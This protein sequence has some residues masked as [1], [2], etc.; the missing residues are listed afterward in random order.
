MKPL[1]IIF[2]FVLL[3]STAFAQ[4][5]PLKGVVKDENEKPVPGVNIVVKGTAHGT[6]T[7]INGNYA[8]DITG[9]E[10]VVLYMLNGYKKFQQKFEAHNGREYLLDVTLVK[11][12]PANVAMKSYGEMDELKPQ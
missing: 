5:I 3:A 11:S 10:V 12:T 1:L 8:M 6:V 9:G 2:S 7:D 4:D